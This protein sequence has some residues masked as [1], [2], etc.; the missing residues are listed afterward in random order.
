MDAVKKAVA[1]SVQ[2]PLVTLLRQ[3][4]PELEVESVEYTRV[5]ALNTQVRVVTKN[6]GIRYFTV[7]VSEML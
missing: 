7:K 2:K 1:E 6:S 3:E 5:N 4:W